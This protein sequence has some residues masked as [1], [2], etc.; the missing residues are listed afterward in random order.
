MTV[1]D[2]AARMESALN[3]LGDEIF[4]DEALDMLD[5]IMVMTAINE[6]NRCAS[7]ESKARFFD[8]LMGE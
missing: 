2:K 6:F 1:S 3:Q 4:R 5:V 8:I 7:S